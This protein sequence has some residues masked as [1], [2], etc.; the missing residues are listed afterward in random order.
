M[1]L[2]SKGTVTFDDVIKLIEEL[3]EDFKRVETSLGASIEFCHNEVAEARKTVEEQ[4]GEISKL[5]KTVDELR[6]ENNGLQRKI[7]DLELR[8]EDYEQYSRHNTVEIHG[9][10]MQKGENVVAIVKDVGRSLGYPIED[11]MI[12]ACHRLRSRVGSDK[13]PGIIVKMVRR[14]DSEE[15]LQKRR[16]K[17]ELLQKRRVK[18]NFNTHDMGLTSGPAV[19]IYINESLSPAR[20]SLYNAARQVKKDKNFEYLWVRSGKIFLRKKQGSN[21]I[22]V[23]KIEDLKDL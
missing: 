13:H 1:A 21:L 16:V 8:V 4:K 18:R 9:V 19:P 11:T 2:E 6:S 10:P 7:A 3:R 14:L 20:R 17:Q 23:R 5:V 12:D 22:T 15:L